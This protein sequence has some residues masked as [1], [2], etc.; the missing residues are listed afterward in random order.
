MLQSMSAA[1]TSWALCFRSLRP[2]SECVALGYLFERHEVLAGIASAA[3]NL[4]RK[5]TSVHAVAMM[6]AHCQRL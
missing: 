4:G 6:F 5:D 2:G 3:A 1:K